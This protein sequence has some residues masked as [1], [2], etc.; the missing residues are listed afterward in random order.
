MEELVNTI[1]EE[2][3]TVLI[4]LEATIQF[5]DVYGIALYTDDS[6]SGVDVD[7]NTRS[8]LKQ[9]CDQIRKERIRDSLEFSAKW[10]TIEWLYEGGYTEQLMK[11]NDMIEKLAEDETD[12]S[13]E[14]ILNSFISALE[15]IS[16]NS[17]FNNQNREELIFQVALTSSEVDDYYMDKSIKELNPPSVYASF[18]AEK[19]KAGE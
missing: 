3:S 12:E 14:R 7:F 2:L 19:A 6:I 10:Y 8:N 11:S 9:K 15:T 4:G 5:G 1:V 18:I 17:V 13:R 16:N